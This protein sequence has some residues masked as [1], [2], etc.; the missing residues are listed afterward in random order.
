MGRNEPT[1]RAGSALGPVN[2]RPALLG[3]ASCA[4]HVD[5]STRL[6]AITPA[7]QRGDGVNGQAYGQS[8]YCRPFT[9]PPFLCRIVA[10]DIRSHN[11]KS[12]CLE[13]FMERSAVG[14]RH[15]NGRSR[16]RAAPP[17]QRS[18]HGMGRPTPV[19][20]LLARDLYRRARLRPRPPPCPA[21]GRLPP[22]D[23]E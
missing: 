22:G 3:P 2:K 19:D 17:K 16:D 8:S 6:S 12:G 13:N 21:H 4:R 11:R 9:S 10:D 14:T 5:L 7:P 18:G 23:R 1:A 20:A 15:F